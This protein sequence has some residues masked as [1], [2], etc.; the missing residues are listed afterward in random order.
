[1]GK[2]LFCRRAI[3]INGVRK[4]TL[5]NC[6]APD[7]AA[8]ASCACFDEKYCTEKNRECNNPEAQELASQ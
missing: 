8:K 5:H 7:E 1:M 4:K 6:V 2:E 3:S